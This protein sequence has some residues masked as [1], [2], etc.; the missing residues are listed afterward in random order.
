MT[1]TV[2][3]KCAIS[4]IIPMYNGEKYIEG[5]L[6]SIRA[7]SMRDLEI[8][9]VNDGSTDGGAQIVQRIAAT[10]ARVTLMEHPQNLGLFQARIT[11]VNASHGD[12]IAFVDADD[13]VSVDWFRLLYE[14]AIGEHSDITVGQFL[15]DFGEGH[16]SFFNLDPL[17]QKI[18]LQG[19][20]VFDA[21]ISQEGGFY[22]W[23][24]IWN[25]LY[26]RV[27]W[28]DA[29][30]D[31]EAFSSAHLHFVM[32]EDIAFSSAM[33]IRARRV[34][35]VQ[36]G[37]YYYYNRAN[38]SQSTAGTPEREKTEKNITNVLNAFAFL[39]EQ[40]EG[41][42]VYE[43]H[44]AHYAAWKLMFARLY[45]TILQSD[46]Q[47]NAKRD[48]AFIREAFQNTEDDVTVYP[49]IYRYYY[50]K[51]TEVNT[52]LLDRMERIK[53]TICDSTKQVISFDVFDT[54]ILRPFWKPTDLF[55]LMTDDFL[56]IC[57]V[58]SF[59]NFV[60]LRIAAEAKCR[61]RIKALHTD[62]DDITLDEIYEQLAMDHDFST[63]E[64][65]ELKA[66]ETRLEIRFC[67]P[68]MM[69]KQLFELAKSQGKTVIICSDMYLPKET[70]EAILKKNGYDYDKLYLSS[71]LRMAKGTRRLYPYVQKKLGVAKSACVHVGDNYESDV[72]AAMDCGWDAFHLPKATDIFRGNV[73]GIYGGDVYRRTLGR[74][75][76]MHDTYNSEVNFL[77]YRTALALVANKFC[78]DPFVT[79]A[80]DSDFNVD[81]YRVG[82]FALGHYLY[83]ITD[84]I[85]KQAKEQG[86]GR[87]HFVARDGYL[88]MEA[89]RELRKYDP[90]LPEENYMYVSR[91]A[92][93]LTDVYER[94]DLYSLWNKLDIT[95][96]S[97][98]KLERMFGTFYRDGAETMEKEITGNAFKKRF[99]S[100]DEFYRAV[101]ALDRRLDY[102]RLLAQKGEIKSYFE[103]I[104]KPT[105][106]L[107]DIGYSG[108]VEAV[109]SKLLGYP[110]NSLYVHG[111]SEFLTNRARI[112]GFRNKSFFDYKPAIT[113][114][115][116]EHVFMKRAPSTIG[117]QRTDDGL[118]PLF[119]KYNT[120]P[121]NEQMTETLQNAALEFVRDFT[122]T[123]EGYMDR[124]TYFKEDMT[125]P[126]EHYLHHSKPA[127]REIFSCVVFEDD[128]G[129]GSEISA[130]GYWNRE[131]KNARLGE[132]GVM[133]DMLCYSQEERLYHT[134]MP[135]SKW[136]KA[137]C[138]LLLEPRQFVGKI[139]RKIKTILG[140]GE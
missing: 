26:T 120:N 103:A 8:I 90:T 54:L 36:G 121:A 80:R 18:D 48:A 27:L 31:L 67:V 85:A 74:V 123:F 72:R 62:Y 13:K 55:H 45:Y 15:C 95:K 61:E 23:Q 44:K 64:L 108:R 124:L 3:H 78:D 134:L 107:F 47:K 30:A 10:D 40:M 17:R 70:V 113:G 57:H 117:Y 111:S 131:L 119:E 122:S 24:L 102:D 104:F 28:M 79:V 98:A 58:S 125:Y 7:Q 16:Y 51:L 109:L 128:M 42:G 86:A 132:D 19:D 101:K 4:V 63:E 105:D 22:S 5:C 20:G 77:G 69:G 71:E 114:V 130:V 33:W 138:Y 110:V 6:E 49:E 137:M 88:P 92:L 29:M 37:A 93:A 43:K 87:L 129:M 35:N 91:K 56:R 127:D 116:R 112:A 106:L 133:A 100:Q 135:Y 41:A 126:F 75:G 96:I 2:E 99:A 46:A 12:Y 21:F 76:A 83:A 32:C 84:W 39:R 97:P 1:R 82:Y 81:P 34:V 52:E 38:E 59:V 66:L 140:R 11:G 73:E 53:R 118:A 136:K 115:V 9:V 60:D 50:S 94:R 139:K 25:K 14:K 68:R 65:D 89:Y